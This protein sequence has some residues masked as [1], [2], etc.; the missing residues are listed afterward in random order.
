MGT[1]VTIEA[2]VGGS[3]QPSQLPDI[4]AQVERA[5]G[6]FSAVECCASRFDA[7]SELR[8]L[9]STREVAVPVSPMLYEML[10]VATALA[11]V[12]GGAFD[13]T[14]GRRME[15]AGFDTH[16]RTGATDRSGDVNPDASWRD[17]ELDAVARTVTLKRS[18]TLDLGALAK[19][20]AID[21][22]AEELREVGGFAI[23]AGGDMRAIASWPTVASR[24]SPPTAG[25]TLDRAPGAFRLRC[26]YVGRL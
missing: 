12:S 11:D 5:L 24:H 17:V 22:A 26:L 7:L 1:V 18:L 15:Q 21:L 16:Y 14:V 4:A 19:G 6:W 2:V 10:R 25:W 13:P 9:C 20:F 23:D 8:R 3:S